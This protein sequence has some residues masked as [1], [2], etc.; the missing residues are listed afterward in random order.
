MDTF[1]TMMPSTDEKLAAPARGGNSLQ[2]DSAMVADRQRSGESRPE[3]RGG[4]GWFWFF[5]GLTLL[6]LACGLVIWLV[7]I[8]PT[9]NAVRSLRDTVAAALSNITGQQITIHAN[10]VTMEKANIAE[11]NLVQRKTQTVVKFE[12]EAFGSK[13]TLIMRGD[14]KVKAGF[15]LSQPFRAEV[16]E[17]TGE[18][19]AEFPPARITSVELKN[20]E[21]FF[22]DNGLINRLKPADQ[23]MATQQMIA[24]AR[25][26]AQRSDII[27]EAEAQ[28]RQRL[29]DL[30]GND[31]RRILLRGA[32]MQ[33]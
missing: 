19:N 28:L 22:A 9:E 4:F 30:I 7:M 21:V 23:E 25:L 33:P 3:R 17:T 20:C 13:K 27:D 8:R 6:V 14:F 18:V 32:E 12:S 10:T 15:D 29:R 1:E 31:A 24:Q 5:A 16:N 11:L 2:S 26:D